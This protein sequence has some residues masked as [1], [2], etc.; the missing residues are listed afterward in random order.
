VALERALSKLRILSRSDAAAAIRKGRVRVDGRIVLN[1]L[2][3]APLDPTR[4]QL[5]NIATS[6]PAWR[7][8][9]LHKPR[10]VV[11]TK[12]D[13]EGRTTVFDLLGAS[14]RGLVA[15]GR[16]DLGTS[17][18]LLLTSDTRLA[19]WLTDPANAVPRVY[20]VTVRGA[21]V[22]ADVRRLISGIVSGGERLRATVA[23]VRKKSARESHLVIELQEG[24]NREIRRLMEAIGHPVTRLKRVQLGALLLGQLAPGEQRELTPEEVAA[25]F[26]GAP[27]GADV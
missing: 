23:S 5:D 21:V 13:P 9:V 17:G 26:P 6:H 22:E 11:T 4:I 14:G 18:L 16:L 7:A 15:V 12:R 20:A 2:A 27:I 24:K 19:D 8:V 1:P 25:A 10:G 3:P